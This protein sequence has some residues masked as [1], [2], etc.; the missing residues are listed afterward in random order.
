MPD[1]QVNILRGAMSS[2]ITCPGTQ[3]LC[4]E[5]AQVTWIGQV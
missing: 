3:G 2:Q 5:E 1:F 4:R